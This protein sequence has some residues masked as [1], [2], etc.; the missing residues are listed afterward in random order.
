MKRWF[1]ISF[2]MIFLALVSIVQIFEEELSK[3]VSELVSEN[4]KDSLPFDIEFEKLVFKPLNLTIA[5]RN[6]NL[7]NVDPSLQEVIP[8]ESIK[9]KIDPY[10]L[11]FGRVLIEKISIDGLHIIAENES[12]SD[13]PFELQDLNIN[14]IFET[15]NQI[16]V[17]TIEINRLSFKITDTQLKSEIKGIIDH[18]EISH[19]YRLLSIKVSN[20]TWDIFYDNKIDFQGKL[21]LEAKLSPNILKIIQLNANSAEKL[22]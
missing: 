8:I 10:E 14:E 21:D 11:F 2:L 6:I 7:K 1:F 17:Q 3:E 9:A 20:L 15:L 16:P 13:E 18:S 22:R 19:F 5:V 12:S 4:L